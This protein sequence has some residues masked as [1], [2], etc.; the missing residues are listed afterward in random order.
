M[1]VKYES[2]QCFHDSLFVPLHSIPNVTIYLLTILDFFRKSLTV[3]CVTLLMADFY[4]FQQQIVYN[5]WKLLVF[6]NRFKP[7]THRQEAYEPLHH[8]N[9]QYGHLPYGNEYF[10]EEKPDRFVVQQVCRWLIS[11]LLIYQYHFAQHIVYTRKLQLASLSCYH[12]MTQCS[13][14]VLQIIDFRSGT[15][16]YSFGAH[17]SSAT[18]SAMAQA[19][20]HGRACS[21]SALGAIVIVNFQTVLYCICVKR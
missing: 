21:Q 6:F 7:F 14:V 2:L 17:M 11:S 9:T 15:S 18:G 1:R 12:N 20:S 5:Y 10:R 13:S 8:T 16:K 19:V 4:S 3:L